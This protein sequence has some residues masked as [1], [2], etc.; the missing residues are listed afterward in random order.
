MLYKRA[1][2]REMK[3]SEPSPFLPL[4]SEIE[5]LREFFLQVA[6]E[7]T[8]ENFLDTRCNVGASKN[9]VT[10]FLRSDYLYI[11][12]LKSFRGGR[13]PGQLQKISKSPIS[14]SES[15]MDHKSVSY[16]HLT[17]SR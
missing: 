5:I 3:P 9:A 12:Y 11:W 13:L 10:H 1:C 16:T 4:K 17:N 6:N 7:Q 2:G 14:D 15:L 8:P